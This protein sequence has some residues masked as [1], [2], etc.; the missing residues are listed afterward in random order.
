MPKRPFV[1]FRFEF[2][3]LFFIFFY[4]EQLGFVHC[5]WWFRNWK[6][7]V[8]SNRTLVRILKFLLPTNTEPSNRFYMQTKSGSVYNM[9]LSHRPD[10]TRLDR[11]ATLKPVGL[12]INH[13]K[14]KKNTNGR[15]KTIKKWLI[16]LY[17]KKIKKLGN[18]KN[19]PKF[20]SLLK[21]D[22]KNC[23]FQ[24][25]PQVFQLSIESFF[26]HKPSPPITL[27]P[28]FLDD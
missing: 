9:V 11:F 4:F 27:S 22:A 10:P 7:K 3:Y 8:E 28:C 6:P 14:E 12:R 1:F 5:R 21:K 20:F 23:L 13:Y 26:G 16:G 18:L 24:N 2:R 15:I 25:F 19:V 17:K